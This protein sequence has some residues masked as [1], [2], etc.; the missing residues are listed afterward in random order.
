MLYLLNY[1]VKVGMQLSRNHISATPSQWIQDNVRRN[2]SRAITLGCVNQKYL[3]TFHYKN[4][5]RAEKRCNRIYSLLKKQ[6]ATINVIECT[7][8]PEPQLGGF[9]TVEELKL[10]RKL[11]MLNM[12]MH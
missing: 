7:N 8:K 5:S 3:I 1:I 4:D 12:S 6:N 11:P 10:V 2:L 9:L